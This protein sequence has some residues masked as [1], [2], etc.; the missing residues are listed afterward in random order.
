MEDTL[1]E[2][3]VNAT[4]VMATLRLNP[5]SSGRYSASMHNVNT[6]NIVAVLILVLVEDTLRALNSQSAQNLIGKS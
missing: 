2:L 5:C 4:L 6:D 3:Q 1:R